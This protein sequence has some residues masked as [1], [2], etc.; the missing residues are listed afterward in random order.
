M[1]GSTPDGVTG[2]GRDARA[3]RAAAVQAST[4]DALYWEC[5]IYP[6]ITNYRNFLAKLV[7]VQDIDL[8]RQ[9]ADEVRFGHWL[10]NGKKPT[11]PNGPTCRVCELTAA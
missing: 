8:I 11:C 10:A 3:D 7:E 5:R 9:Y 2:P 6:T 1:N 4:V